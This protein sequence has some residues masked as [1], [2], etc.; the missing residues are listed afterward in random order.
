MPSHGSQ[1]PAEQGHRKAV[2]P[3]AVTHYSRRNYTPLFIRR[4]DMSVI[5]TAVDCRR[6]FLVLGYTLSQRPIKR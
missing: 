4:D 1:P 5:G 2:K 3:Y 6:V